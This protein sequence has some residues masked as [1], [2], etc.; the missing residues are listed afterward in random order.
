MNI[1]VLLI[2]LRH[3]MFMYIH[4]CIHMSKNSMKQKVSTYWGTGEPLGREGLT[5]PFVPGYEARVDKN[6]H[7][8]SHDFMKVKGYWQ[9]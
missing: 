1:I 8:L 5:S 4:R 7:R 9:W 3:V 2:W 6:N